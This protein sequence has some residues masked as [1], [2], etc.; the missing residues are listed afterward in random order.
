M[1]SFLAS[2]RQSV[3][4]SRRTQVIPQD[5]LQALH[6]HHLTLSALILH[7]DPPVLPEKSQPPLTAEIAEIDGQSVFFPTFK[8]ILDEKPAGQSNAYIPNHFPTLPGSHTYKATEDSTKRE[9]DP[10]KIRERA[11]E[12]GRLGEEALRRLVGTGSQLGDSDSIATKRKAEDLRKR[13]N[14]LWRKTMDAVA[15]ETGPMPGLARDISGDAM[16]TLSNSPFA[17]P[18]RQRLTSAVNAEKSYWRK[19]ARP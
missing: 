12:E 16:E 11:T 9:T 6:E 15:R 2:V 10:R 19:G 3:L 5:Y 4:S 18:E 13:R 7:L 1:V 14:E 17:L 8:P